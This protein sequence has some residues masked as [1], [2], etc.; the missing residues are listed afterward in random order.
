[1]GIFSLKVSLHRVWC[2]HS[3]E[4]IGAL[5]HETNHSFPT[6]AIVE[7]WWLFRKSIS[8]TISEDIL[9]ILWG[10]FLPLVVTFLNWF[11]KMID[12]SLSGK[13][14]HHL[15]STDITVVFIIAV[16]S[17]V[18]FPYACPGTRKK[19]SMP[20]SHKK[21]AEKKGVWQNDKRLPSIYEWVYSIESDAGYNFIV[22]TLEREK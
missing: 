13:P 8:T 12:F 4:A 21:G 11:I 19:N 1:M 6:T 18:H 22:S 10:I 20:L 9:W 2:D 3:L 17:F 14:N 5:F 15:K 16:P 7:T